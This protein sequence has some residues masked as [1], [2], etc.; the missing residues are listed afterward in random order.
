LQRKGT[1]K[2][3]GGSQVPVAQPVILATQEAETRGIVVRS[4]PGQ[5]VFK[6]LS[7]K[8][9]SP[10]AGGVAQGVGPKFKPQY[11]KKKKKKKDREAVWAGPRLERKAGR[12]AFQMEGTAA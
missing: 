3:W 9:S 1:W 11:H 8:N 10:R 4:Q 2:E 5:I 12:T 6:T 7:R